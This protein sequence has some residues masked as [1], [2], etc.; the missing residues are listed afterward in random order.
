MAISLMNLYLT[1]NTP[2]AKTGQRVHAFQKQTSKML[3]ILIART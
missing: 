1:G 2:A 3:F